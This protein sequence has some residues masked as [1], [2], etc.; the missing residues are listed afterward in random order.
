VRNKCTHPNV[1]INVTERMAEFSE[2][3]KLKV[4]CG[5]WNVS[6]KVF[7]SASSLESSNSEYHNICNWLTCDTADI[8]AIGLEEMVC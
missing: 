2:A 6:G 1:V 7:N 3:S 4:F 8:Y 5:T